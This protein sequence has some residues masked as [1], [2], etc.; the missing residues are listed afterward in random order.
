MSAPA[1]WR[2]GRRGWPT[3]SIP[4]VPQS[5]EQ[6]AMQPWGSV[7][8]MTHGDVR[9][10]ESVAICNYIDN[11]FDGPPLQPADPLANARCWQWTSV[12]IQYLYRP[13]IDIVLQRLIVPAQGGEPDEALVESSVPKSD[14]ALIALD[15]AL[16]GNACFAGGEA[17]IADYMVLPVL[18]YLKMTPEGEGFA[19]APRQHRPLAGSH[20][21]ARERG[22]DGARVRVGHDSCHTWSPAHLPLSPLPRRAEGERKL[23]SLLPLSSPPGEERAGVRRGNPRTARHVN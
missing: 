3:S 15:G 2:A 23:R 5:D 21:R 16:E 1:A 8:A 12:F 22:R 7:P 4:F 17:S 14:K 20:R 13:A 9:M 10:Y 11:A 18:H 19:R 6:K